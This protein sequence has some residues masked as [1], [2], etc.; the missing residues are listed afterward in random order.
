MTVTH[1]TWETSER[2]TH[3]IKAVL[4]LLRFYLACNEWHQANFGLYRLPPNER[5][6][7]TIS[8]QM[9]PPLGIIAHTPPPLDSC[10]IWSYDIWWLGIFPLLP[11][12]QTSRAWYPLSISL[13][14]TATIHDHLGSP[15]ATWSPYW[16]LI[17]LIQWT[18]C[19]IPRSP[20]ITQRG[21]QF[22]QCLWQL[23]S[24]TKI[25]EGMVEKGKKQQHDAT[26][27]TEKDYGTS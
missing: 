26:E 25:M 12:L 15:P 22:Y 19:P 6:I 17:H 4:S 27:L 7:E 18:T 8:A 21:M 11:Q 13:D 5:L 14:P 16:L 23:D 9:K 10:S 20:S 2:N 1:I 3:L 24:W